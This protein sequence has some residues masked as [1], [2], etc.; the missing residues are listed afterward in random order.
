MYSNITY[1]ARTHRYCS[2]EIAKRILGE[3]TKEQVEEKV[4]EKNVTDDDGLPYDLNTTLEHMKRIMKCR[5]EHDDAP[6]RETASGRYRKTLGLQRGVRNTKDI[7][8]T[9]ERLRM[10]REACEREKSFSERQEYQHFTR[11]REMKQSA[12]LMHE[13]RR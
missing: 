13:S 12:Q 2:S 7:R 4:E 8:N 1:N 5:A 6:C 3:E 11:H 10:L 9:H